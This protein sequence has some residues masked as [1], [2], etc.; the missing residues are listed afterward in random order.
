VNRSLQS[1]R[2]DRVL[3]FDHGEAFIPV[4]S[5]LED[6]AGF[7]KGYLDAGPPARFA[8]R[9]YSVLTE[10][11][12]NGSDRTARDEGMSQTAED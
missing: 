10:D 3:H 12:S 2:N 7:D 5:A 11:R 4:W 8:D 6:M 9:G 1:L